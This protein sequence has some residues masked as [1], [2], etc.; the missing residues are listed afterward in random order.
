MKRRD[1]IQETIDD[2]RRYADSIG[3]IYTK[4][5]N[6]EITVEEFEEDYRDW[7]WNIKE[8]C[9]DEYQSPNNHCTYV[10]NDKTE[11]RSNDYSE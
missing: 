2:F 4:L 8:T 10:L 1:F 5:K 9:E 7:V 11:V 6:K 3:L